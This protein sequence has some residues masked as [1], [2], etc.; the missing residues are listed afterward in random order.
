MQITG[1]SALQKALNGECLSGLYIA[2]C[3]G[4]LDFWKPSLPYG[5]DADSIVER[6]DRV[7]IDVV[8]LNKWN[9]PDLYSANTDV[10]LAQ[11]KYPDRI[12]AFAATSPAIGRSRTTDELRRCFDE[13]GFRGIKVHNAYEQLPLRNQWNLPEYQ[14]AVEAIWEFA[15]NARCPVLCHGFLTPEI[16]VRY[17]DAAFIYAH[18][19]SV[20]ESVYMYAECDNVYLDTAA[21]T[22]L[23]GN[24]RYLVDH[25]RVDRILYGSDLPIADPA[26]RI[27]QIL[28][29]ELS[30]DEL[31]M[32]MGLNLA[33]LLDLP[34]PRK[35]SGC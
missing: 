32:I 7:G 25:G 16:A 27:G 18:A 4:H 34:I 8:C 21:S 5:V 17:P 13:L 31:K 28:S 23:R 12:V 2:D 10:G 29:S 24:V 26:Y 15:A 30:E 20:R 22:T 9:C 11:K 3:H 14:Q 6:M 33:R 35:Y 1:D 19:A